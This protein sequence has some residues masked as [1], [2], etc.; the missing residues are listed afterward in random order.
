M[1]NIPE[2]RLADI[3][4]G[5]QVELIVDALPDRT[6]IGTLTW[7]AA[8]VDDRTRMARARVEV[9]NA[10]GVLRAQMFARARIL[11][12]SAEPA[13]S[14][15][16]SA[17]QRTDGAPMVFVRLAD[18]LYE[19]RPVLLGAKLNGSVEVL[20]GISAEDQV[21][22][23]NGFVAKSQLLLSRLGAGCVDE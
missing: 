17:V 3:R 15:P 7:I 12:A 6:F 18:D 23:A 8:R 5:Q 11:T 16:Q 13:L 2:K 10:D 1:L 19:A 21:V 22:T 4:V 20:E 9:P 14:V